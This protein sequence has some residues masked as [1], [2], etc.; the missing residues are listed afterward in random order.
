MSIKSKISLTWSNIIGILLT[1]AFSIV[2][3]IM[4]VKYESEKK[5]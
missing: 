4:E 1:N 5:D 2:G 3:T